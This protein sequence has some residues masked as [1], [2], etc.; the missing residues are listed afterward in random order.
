M[1]S[2]KDITERLKQKTE[3]DEKA[4]DAILQLLEIEEEHKQYSKPYKTI[5]ENDVKEGTDAN[6]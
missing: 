3:G 2:N 4:F 5:I 6:K 1:I